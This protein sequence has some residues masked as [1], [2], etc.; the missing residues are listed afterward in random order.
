MALKKCISAATKLDESVTQALLDSFDSYALTMSQKKATEFAIDDAIE[1]TTREREETLTMI[2]AAHPD[3]DP[4]KKPVA[5]KRPRKVVSP[6]KKPPMDKEPAKTEEPVLLAKRGE[7]TSTP[8]DAPPLPAAERPQIIIRANKRIIDDGR[9]MI[10]TTPSNIAYQPYDFVQVSPM[11]TETPKT[12]LGINA[13]RSLVRTLQRDYPQT[14]K[15]TFHL[16]ATQDE[17]FGPNSIEKEGIIQGGY[18]EGTDEIILIAEHFANAKDAI[19][20]IRHE[21]VS[22]FGLRQLLNKDG[23]YNRL[24]DRVW[25]SRNG[26]LKELYDWVADYYR[27]LF[28]GYVRPDGSVR[29]DTDA[30]TIADEMLARAGEPGTKPTG[31]IERIYDE[32]IRLLQKFGWLGVSDTITLKEVLKLIRLSEANLRRKLRPSRPIQQP[33]RA[34]MASRGGVSPIWKSGLVEAVKAI[35]QAKGTGEQYLN[36]I[37]KLSKKFFLISTRK[38]QPQYAQGVT[39]EEFE[40]LG[41]EEFLEGKGKITKDEIVAFMEAGGVRVEDVIL[42][43]NPN[44]PTEQALTASIQAASD[45]LKE[46]DFLGF[47]SI[48]LARTAV[49]THDDYAE[50]WD[51]APEHIEVLDKYRQMR[52]ASLE[53]SGSV[54]HSGHV[55]PGG[56]NYREILL[57]LPRIRP[58]AVPSTAM[59]PASPATPTTAFDVTTDQGIKNYLRWLVGNGL[60][61]HFDDGVNDI[62]FQ[63]A[64]PEQIEV[65]RQ[66]NENLPDDM[67][68]WFEAPG[69]EGWYAAF[70]GEG[71]I[72]AATELIITPEE[73]RELVDERDDVWEDISQV[74]GFPSDAHP[75][76]QVAWARENAPTAMFSTWS[77]IVDLINRPD[78]QPLQTIPAPEEAYTSGHWGQTKNILAHIR[79]NERMVN[80]QRVLFIEEIQSDWHQAGRKHGYKGRSAT[81]Q[82]VRQILIEEFGEKGREEFETMGP[83]LVS[84]FN[85]PEEQRGDLVVDGG[86]TEENEQRFLRRAQNFG[87]GG[88]PDA[89]F[90]KSW[91]LLALKRMIRY[92][93][94]NGYDRI[95]WTTGEQQKKRYALTRQIDKLEVTVDSQGTY[96]LEGT[97]GGNHIVTKENIPAHMLGEYIGDELA[98]QV[99]VGKD[100]STALDRMN[101]KLVTLDTDIQ[102]ITDPFKPAGMNLNSW[103]QSVG[104]LTLEAVKRGHDKPPGM[105][106]KMDKFQWGSIRSMAEDRANLFEQ[107]MSIEE[108]TQVFEGLDLEIGGSGMLGFYDQMLVSM[109][110]NY[111]KKYKTRV[112]D[113]PLRTNTQMVGVPTVPVGLGNIDA[114]TAE[115]QQW[116]EDNDIPVE[117]RGSADEMLLVMEENEILDDDQRNW[118]TDFIQRWEVVQ[119]ADDTGGQ[120]ALPAPTDMYAQM[121][122]DQLL[123]MLVWNDRNGEFDGS[124]E[125]LISYVR[126]QDIENEGADNALYNAWVERTGLPE[127]WEVLGVDELADPELAREDDPEANFVVFSNDTEE[128][129]S[130]IIGSGVTEAMA[131][132]EAHLNMAMEGLPMFPVGGL[133]GNLPAPTETFT[134]PTYEEIHEAVAAYMN[135]DLS[136]SDFNDAMGAEILDDENFDEIL[137]EGLHDMATDED[138]NAVVERGVTIIE[139]Q[140]R[141]IN[142]IRGGQV[143]Q[144]ANQQLALPAPTPAPHGGTITAPIGGPEIDNIADM[145]AREFTGEDNEDMLGGVLFEMVERPGGESVIR[146]QNFGD[147]DFISLQVIVENQGGRWTETGRATARDR[148]GGEPER[149]SL[150]EAAD[151]IG[152]NE[153]DFEG[154]EAILWYPQG[155]YINV[156]PDGRYY[157]VAQQD[158]RIF[159]DQ[160]EAEEYLYD[161]MGGDIED[162]YPE[163]MVLEAPPLVGEAIIERPV[164][165]ADIRE[166]YEV[167]QA[168]DLWTVTRLGH[169]LSDGMMSIQEAEGFMEAEILSDLQGRIGA[170]VTVTEELSQQEARAHI[171]SLAVLSHD[172]E[173]GTNEQIDNANEAFQ[174]ASDWYGIDWEEGVHA[175]YLGHAT[176]EEALNYLMMNIGEPPLTDHPTGAAQALVQG[177]VQVQETVDVPMQHSFPLSDELRES[178]LRGQLMFRRGDPGDRALNEYRRA[179]EKRPIVGWVDEPITNKDGSYRKNAAGDITGAPLGTRTKRQIPPII[180][181]MIRFM[182]DAM[183]QMPVS[184]EWYE[185][186]GDAIRKIVHGDAQLAERM[187][188]I[189]AMLS[190]ANQVGGNTTG[191]IKAIYQ[192]ARGETMVAG[193]FPNAFA[194]AIAPVLAADDMGTHLPK[195]E[196]KV[197]SFYR[198]LWDATFKSRKYEMTAT[199]DM[200]MARVFGY[201]T[202]TFSPAQYRFANMLLLKTTEKYNKK[203]GTNLKPRQV[204]AALWVYARNAEKK[205]AG[206]EVDLTADRSAFDTYIERATQYITVEAVPSNDS[207]EFPEIHLMTMT[208]RREYTRQAIGLILN[209]KGE[210][211]LF[212]RLGIPL[213]TSTPSE[214]SFEGAV[215]PNQILGVVSEKRAAA[216]AFPTIGIP[217]GVERSRT[218]KTKLL[219]GPLTEKEK[220]LR[221]IGPPKPKQMPSFEASNLAS[222]ALRLIY[223]Q[224]MVPWFQLDHTQSGF[225]RGVYIGFNKKPTVAMEKRLYKHINQYIDADFTRLQ[226]GLL[227]LNYDPEVP[228]KGFIAKIE[229]AVNDYG[230]QGLPGSET[231]TEVATDVKAKSSDYKTVN[232]SWKNPAEAVETLEASLRDSGS[233]GLLSWVRSRRR[234]VK[235]LQS[236]FS[237]EVL[238]EK[239]SAPFDPKDP[240]LKFARA[241][242]TAQDAPT[243]GNL[244]M[245]DEKLTDKF[246][247]LAQDNFN[248]VKTLQKTILKGGGTVTLDSDV[249]GT[250]ERSSSK[251]SFR[252]LKLD[253]QYMQPLLEHMKDNDISVDELDVYLVARHAVER[254]D[255]IASINKKMPDGGSG[256]TNQQAAATLNSLTAE[257]KKSLAHAAGFIDSVNQNHLS[258]LVEGGHIDQETVD[259]WQEMYQFYVPLKG[260]KDEGARGM[261]PGSGYSISGSGILQAMGRGE[262]NIAESPTAH[263]FAQ[264]ESAIVRT[265]KSKVGRALVELVKQNPDPKLWKLS[266][267]TFK[268][269][270]DLYGEPFEG[271]PEDEAPPGM[272]ENIDF[273]RVRAISKAERRLAKE[274]GREPRSQVVYRLD[275]NYRQQDDVFAVMDGGKE[276]LIKIEDPILVA[277]LKKMSTTQLGAV[278]RFFGAVNRY[279]AMINTAL[280]PEFV[281]T[282]FERDFQTAMINLGGEHSAAI[283]GKVMTSIPGAIRGIL[284]STFNTKGKS[285]WRTLYDEMQEEG[286]AIGFFGLEDIETKVKKI[287]NRLKGHGGVLGRTRKGIN[288]VRDAVLDANLSVENAARLAA[289]KIIKEEAIAN[290]LSPKEAKARAASVSKNLTVNFNRK[291][292]LAPV[293]NSLYLFYNASIQG[294]ARIFSAL[295]HKRVRR[296]AGGVVAT[297]FALAAYNREMGGDDDDEI[298]YWDKIN[299][300]LKST[301][302][303][304]MHPDGSG[305]YSKIKLPYGYNVFAY[306]GTA[307]YDLMM[308]PEM[309]VTRTT[310]NLLS[311]VLNAFNPIQGADLVDT[312]TPTFAKPVEQDYRNINFMGA[313][314]KP[315]NP[316]DNYDRPESDKAWKSTNPLLKDTM[317]TLNE[318]GFGT[319]AFKGG[320]TTHSG[321]IDISPEIVKHYTSWLTGGAGMF[322][323]RSVGTAANLIQGEE[324]EQKDI[325]FLRTLGG[326]PGAHFD[327][328]RYYEAIKQVNAVKA[329]I[330]RIETEGDKQDYRT[331]WEPIDRLRFDAKLAQ[332]EISMLRDQREQAYASEDLDRANELREEIRQAMM[333]FSLKYYAAEEEMYGGY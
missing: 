44:K 126:E 214:G 90:K 46:M 77:R 282:N 254:N 231:I 43:N 196:S 314:L 250:E 318:V 218:K 59:V 87:L 291:G 120:L 100:T 152:M 329:A 316:F 239:G 312:L 84:Y 81:P 99:L 258:D 204:Q 306:T 21:T 104:I 215:N 274:E 94:E 166:E 200:W 249:Y 150:A 210:N 70:N 300:Y 198:N 225:K 256:L 17:A 230:A 134:M 49:Y 229:E 169:V 167:G 268:K 14:R 6:D 266:T 205:E 148:L 7:K 236:Q 136:L 324:I 62:Q 195:V 251:I 83:L 276:L 119:D 27:D 245:P 26:E 53:S 122:R 267:R 252:L 34:M 220:R 95:S 162:L 203:H 25:R 242:Q 141:T 109:A 155:V 202:D 9:G 184:A 174:L 173:Y 160:V 199:M 32:I 128:N 5:K 259:E 293:M 305:N 118:L 190:A 51:V 102:K 233:Q 57:T 273:K 39:E 92:A 125:D 201:E 76:A 298:P 74:P 88:V 110:N 82:M 235:R 93:A 323:W 246:V 97:R 2:Y 159:D 111:L 58:A 277:Q 188:R 321:L 269:F 221:T 304:F 48:Q 213:Y 101:K 72:P 299:P 47:G 143:V 50:R 322:A 296:I 18:I 257:R 172:A 163:Q 113:F 244:G 255:Y 132:A 78:P 309:T 71:P 171:R 154:S 98:E 117:I 140:L 153:E 156:L 106:S 285:E 75:V 320:D 181:R 189:M 64:S 187:I 129:A 234:A 279:L 108:G 28:A 308:D 135:G 232:T 80:G 207:G 262:G 22:H 179:Q 289:Y 226:E 295:Q 264:A 170:E 41:I 131:I 260:K 261:G 158:D 206:K 185:V 89:P 286:G 63:N 147:P 55:L 116:M 38:G 192:I 313:P 331:E 45:A 176:D 238:K 139:N 307:M 301:N 16:Y 278:T 13:L 247:R 208:K 290:G 138:N 191:V 168:D 105:L 280:N 52:K 227:L 223:T 114:L 303:I 12:S 275:P 175:Q 145:L 327:T 61:Y 142:A 60:A 67:W 281:I 121:S 79:F 8:R 237:Q 146:F 107:W 178:A 253:K 4:D 248:R 11:L 328:A 65:I 68:G 240:N 177:P 66:T 315:D 130:A 112:E 241:A 56:T 31:L 288:A 183:S 222:V 319:G 284:Q 137:P 270:V 10:S 330:D 193:R 333:K 216:G 123:A 182:E 85:T 217:Q 271:Y 228:N 23:E 219:M 332:R 30:R 103:R 287:Q 224:D 283:A 310:M 197:M 157:V 124:T 180:N 1:N 29:Q 33:A 96:T 20:V 302:I 263:T 42:G 15:A 133:Q 69:N 40:W 54:R 115:Y 35:K 297:F 209:D 294:S 265:E 149:L 165:E 211:E 161:L 91:P 272:S 151:R 19:T 326:K 243:G 292:E 144:P 311:A 317:A 127:G 86:W 194:E 37:R 212:H 36:Q 24:L 3:L 325:P 73:Q 164:T 186:S